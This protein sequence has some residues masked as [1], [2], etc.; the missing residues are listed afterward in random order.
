MTGAV[1]W[2]TG[3]PS[4]GKSTLARSLAD[5]LRGTSVPAV[6]LDGDEVRLALEPAPDYSLQGRE[7]FYETLARLAA[8]LARQ[9]LVVLVAAT[10]HRRAYR[11]R[12]RELAPRYL[13]V[14]VDVPATE[15]ARRDPK[16]LYAAAADGRIRGLPGQDVPFERP[17]APD[18][19]ADGGHDPAAISR[20]LDLVSP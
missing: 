7:R 17:E 20:I 5:R 16:G 6:V 2:F 19:I 15:C 3:L 1:V 8:L 14:F 9:D 13:E 12:A 10:A 18:V 4:S 11:E